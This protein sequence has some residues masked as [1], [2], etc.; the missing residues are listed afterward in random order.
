M[1]VYGTGTYTLKRF[2]STDAAL[3]NTG[4]MGVKYLILQ[5]YA[6]LYWIPIFPI[7][8]LHAIEKQGS[9]DKYEVSDQNLMRL[10]QTTPIPFWKHLL[11][12]AG[13]LLL[14]LGFGYYNIQNNL[15]SAAYVKAEKTQKEERA[16]ILADTASLRPYAN[17]FMSIISCL[18]KSELE[19]P[20]HI[21]KIDTNQKEIILLFI[22][23]F[24]ANRDTT[25]QYSNENTLISMPDLGFMES[26]YQAESN[27]SNVFDYYF[28]HCFTL[29]NDLDDKEVLRWYQSGLKAALPISNRN[30]NLKDLNQYLSKSKYV[31]NVHITGYAAPSIMSQ[32]NS[33]N[34]G[35]MSAKVVV[36]EAATRKLVEKYDI[37][38]T[39]SESISFMQRDN[40]AVSGSDFN[41][42]LESDL[43]SNLN[44]QI[45]V[46]LRLEKP[47]ANNKND[48][49]QIVF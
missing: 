39:N 23:C 41:N 31:A 13:P 49:N 16:K 3:Q 15:E 44:K 35:Y 30:T 26:E 47:S 17:Q 32:K 43:R 5:R 11:A 46:S 12:F 22:K 27:E 34:A 6:H 24:A 7:G 2:E 21:E 4:L 42:R 20:L 38:S 9:S 18:E 25:I 48:L 10:M 1:I 19:K 36:Y 40:Q 8:T 14:I 29:H 45:R 37:I 28:N 33:Y